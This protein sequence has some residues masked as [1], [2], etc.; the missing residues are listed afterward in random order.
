MVSAFSCAVDWVAKRSCDCIFPFSPT[1]H[2]SNSCPLP[3]FFPSLLTPL[4]SSH[5]LVYPTI[6]NVSS[7]GEVNLSL[8][9]ALVC[10]T[11]GFPL[12]SIT[13]QKEGEEVMLT[14]DGRISTFIG[15]V[16][17]SFESSGN[18]SIG[19]LLVSMTE[20]NTCDLRSLGELGV[21]SVLSFG[22]LEREDTANYT[23]TATNMLPQTTTL[24]ALSPS[25]P[26]VVLGKPGLTVVVKSYLY[27]YTVFLFILVYFNVSCLLVQ[28]S[29]LLVLYHIHAL[30]LSLLILL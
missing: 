27:M 8:P 15:N 6:N 20:F 19:G 23:C 28:T 11:T 10:L 25:I 16:S 5:T 24:T 22:R 4:L 29:K 21:V 13:W 26:L 1:V 18:G 14:M 30:I 3:C 12:P 17:S 9:M 2:T 7:P